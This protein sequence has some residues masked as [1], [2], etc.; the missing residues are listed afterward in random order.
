MLLMMAVTPA[1]VLLAILFGRRLR[2][3]SSAVQDEL[4]GATTVL[5]ESIAGV[6]VVQSFTREQYE[7][8]RFRKSIEATFAL[9]MKRMRLSSTFGPLITFLAFSAIVA[10]LWFGGRQVLA[11]DLT[12]G[13]LVTFLILT[14]TLAGSIGQ[15]SGL[16]AG[17]QE[18]VGA[19]PGAVGS[20]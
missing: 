19:A 8:G 9:A 2:K 20:L 13:Q 15:S 16:W 11:G 10:I 18:G 4:A 6:R 17:V 5:E 14:M 1:V 12:T 3:L 7:I